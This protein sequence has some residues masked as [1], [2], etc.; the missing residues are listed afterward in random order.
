MDKVTADAGDTG[1]S[2]VGLRYLL[3][4]I[5]ADYRENLVVTAVVAAGPGQLWTVPSLAAEGQGLLEMLGGLVQ[6]TH[7]LGEEAQHFEED[8][9]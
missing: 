8:I 6:V 7:G 5:I 4:E 3:R 9:S 1:G 2:S